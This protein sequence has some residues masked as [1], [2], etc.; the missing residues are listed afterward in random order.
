MKRILQ[1]AAVLQ[2][3]LCVWMLMRI[4]DVVS[5]EPPSFPEL[6]QSG[7]K[8]PLPPAPQRRKVPT[9]VT[10]AINDNNL[11][12]LMRGERD[13][14]IAESVEGDGTDFEEPPVPPPTTIELAGVILLPPDPVAIMSDSAAGVGQRRLRAGDLIGDYEVGAISA[15]SVELKGGEG[16]SYTVAL[17]VRPGDSSGGQP[18]GARPGAAGA[19]NRGAPA[20]PNPAA[21]PGA[22]APGGGAQA[23]K[24]MTARERAAAIA[25]ARRGGDDKQAEAAPKGP[26]PVEARLEALRRLRDAAKNR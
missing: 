19:N 6:S 8:L 7:A 9:A 18:A 15:Q 14:V 12:E 11:F 20:R 3:V 17:Q 22:N 24:A 2:G 16:Q 13:P 26:N 23:Q 4:V 1:L 25:R 10:A 21:R 5:M